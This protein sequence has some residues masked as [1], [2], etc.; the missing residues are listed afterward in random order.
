[1]KGHKMTFTTQRYCHI[2]AVTALAFGLAACGKGN[3]N[4][5]A[6]QKLDSAVA[7]TQQA[8]QTAGDKVQEGAAKAGDATASALNTAGDKMG[9]AADTAGAKIE[10][11]AA[12][13]GAAL[14]D[15]GI[16]AQVKTDLI[17]EPNISALKIDVDTKAGAVTLTGTVPSE[18]LKTRAGEIATAV[19]GVGSVNNML[20]IQA[21]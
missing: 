3:D 6:G 12:K 10:E 8:A 1:M 14:D 17:K 9:Q 21:S 20:T 7:Q 19:K 5:T 18:A 15:A 13:A 16:T 4:Q 2:L 11:G